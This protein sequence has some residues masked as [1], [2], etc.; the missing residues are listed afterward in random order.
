MALLEYKSDGKITLDCE[1]FLINKRYVV[2]AAR[3]INEQLKSVRLGETDLENDP[4]CIGV[5]EFIE[6]PPPIISI[7]IDQK[8]IYNMSSS[9][10]HYHIALLR[11]KSEVKFSDFVQPICLPINRSYNAGKQLM[12][13]GWERNKANRKQ[14][15]IKGFC[16]G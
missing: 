3:C 12:V 5:N 11:L 14:Q 2:T 15:E 4:D 7:P 16:N 13:S 6:C 1:G 8:I 10:S 9:Q